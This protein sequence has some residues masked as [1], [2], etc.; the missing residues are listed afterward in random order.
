MYTYRVCKIKLQTV[1]S[2]ADDYIR[3]K[4]SDFS[5]NLTVYSSFRSSVNIE[6]TF[7]NVNIMYVIMLN[8][9]HF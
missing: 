6:I 9:L 2:V 8:R 4:L 1:H 3:N 5:N 7:E